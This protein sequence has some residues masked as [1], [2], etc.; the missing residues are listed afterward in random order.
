[1]K[2]SSPPTHPAARLCGSVAALFLLFA[3]NSSARMAV[4]GPTARASMNES[5]IRMMTADK[6]EA[7]WRVLN[8]GNMKTA[9]NTRPATITGLRPTLSE[10]QPVKIVSGKRANVPQMLI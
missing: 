10:S 6:L 5:P 1:M 2:G 3:G 8:A 4:C 7:D 9:P